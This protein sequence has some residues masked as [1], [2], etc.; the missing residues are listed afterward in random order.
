MDRRIRN[1]RAQEKGVARDLAGRVTPGSGN[2]WFA[3]NDV[4][5]PGWSIE[6]KTTQAKSFSLRLDVLR[7]AQ[8]NALLDNREMAV[9]VEIQG[10]SWVVL[11]YASFLSLLP[12]EET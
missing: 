5:A 8:K 9:I 11:P 2:K 6:C 3:K 1:S 12:Q 7:T 10:H 4:L